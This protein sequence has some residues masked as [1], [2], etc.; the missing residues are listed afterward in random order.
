MIRNRNGRSFS[1]EVF[2]VV[3]FG[4]WVKNKVD[5]FY[6]NPKKAIQDIFDN[7]QYRRF[8]YFLALS[9]FSKK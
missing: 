7:N 1:P 3:D 6:Q 8:I 2:S 4:I 9:K 5:K